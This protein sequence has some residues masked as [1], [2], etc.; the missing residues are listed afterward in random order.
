MANNYGYPDV[1]G[2]L[3][4]K[5]IDDL[6]KDRTPEYRQRTNDMNVLVKNANTEE[7]LNSALAAF[8]QFDKDN[9][10]WG[11][12][13]NEM[14]DI[15]GANLI[16][17]SNEFNKFKSAL[18]QSQ[19]Y[20]DSGIIDTNKILTYDMDDFTTLSEEVRKIGEIND[21]LAS[22][23]ARNFQHSLGS[24]SQSNEMLTRDMKSRLESINSTLKGLAL[25]GKIPQELAETIIMGEDP[26]PIINENKRRIITQI[27]KNNSMLNF[28]KKIIARSN[29]AG[30]APVA[31]MDEELKDT[32]YDDADGNPL[33]IN[34]LSLYEKSQGSKVSNYDNETI[35][36]WIQEFEDNATTLNTEYLKWSRSKYNTD[37]NIENLINK[38]Q[39]DNNQET[40]G[41]WH[42]PFIIEGQEDSPQDSGTNKESSE[43]EKIQKLGDIYS[44]SPTMQGIASFEKIKNEYISEGSP[45]DVSGWALEM[46]NLPE[47]EYY[48]TAAPKEKTIEDTDTTIVSDVIIDKN[49][50][51]GITSNNWKSISTGLAA[52]GA[53]SYKDKLEKGYNMATNSLSKASRYIHS[54]SKLSAPQITQFLETPSVQNTLNNIKKQE[55]KIKNLQV[56]T[57]EYK[58]AKKRLN[59]IM[60]NRSSYWAK[61]FT[62]TMNVS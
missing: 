46:F 17:K 23:K 52:F 50:K 37:D 47:S 58:T 62:C 1:S 54:A 42:P 34:F 49:D 53:Y 19:T 15:T 20:Y 40:E 56:G 13:F 29:Q 38:F 2:I 31:V 28:A 8:K 22:G 7:G 12:E 14:G 48:L 16:A 39:N 59:N 9:D 21:I 11:A 44:Q 3:L 33:N 24:G 6:F 61:K 18:K 10:N 36:K 30:G 26:I 41:K 60:N 4:N 55:D 51:S 27:N 25:T 43:G 32:T 57:E 35:K 5:L 45:S